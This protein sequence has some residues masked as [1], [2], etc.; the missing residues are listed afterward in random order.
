MSHGLSGSLASG[1]FLDQGSNLC[2][3]HWQTNS[4]PWYPQGSPITN[5]FKALFLD[6]EKSE[7]STNSIQ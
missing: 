2:P 6:F 3:L 7:L 4:Y 5:F 1:I